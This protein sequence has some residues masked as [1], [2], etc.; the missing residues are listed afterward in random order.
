M[1]RPG[2]GPQRTAAQASFR[3]ATDGKRLV[4]QTDPGWAYH[5]GAAWQPETG[6]WA[7]PVAE[8][9]GQVLP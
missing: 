8:L 5:P 6:R 9:A 2:D 7:G 4:V 1:G 3:T